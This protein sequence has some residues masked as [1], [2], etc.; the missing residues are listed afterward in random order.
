M[1]DG[2]DI[3]V[4][5]LTYCRREELFYGTSLVFRTLRVGFPNARVFVTD[6]AS[7]AA[8]RS[9][10]G[11][12]ARQQGC[13]WTQID[14]AIGHDEF[15]GKTLAATAASRPGRRLVFLDPDVC[16]WRNCE[17]FEFPGLVAGR[18]LAAYDDP[19]MRCVMMPR[20]HTSFMWIPDARAL[21]ARIEDIR[22]RHFDFHP[23]LSFSVRLGDAWLRYDTAA[24]LCAAIPEEVSPFTTDHLDHFDHL[25]CGSHFDLLAP[26]YPPRVREAMSRIHEDARLGRIENLKGVWRI[27]DRIWFEDYERIEPER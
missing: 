12:L 8:V 26:V 2:T 5:I 18:F 15:I 9:R 11:E 27:Q 24:S 1:A 7:V 14:S 10:I 6:N 22:R 16:L 23:F 17:G 19:I 21:A 3:D 4:H 25:L 13:E 20:I